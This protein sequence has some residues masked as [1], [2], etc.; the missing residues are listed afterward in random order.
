VEDAG[1]GGHVGLEVTG[2]VGDGGKGQ[3]QVVDVGGLSRKGSLVRMEMVMMSGFTPA[4]SCA[5][6]GWLCLPCVILGF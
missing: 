3:G 5:I 6:A 1:E 4:S 2:E